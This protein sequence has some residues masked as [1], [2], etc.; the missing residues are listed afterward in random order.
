MSTLYNISLSDTEYISFGE[1]LFSNEKSYA[2][3]TAIYAGE[4]GVVYKNS[5]YNWGMIPRVMPKK[6]KKKFEFL[7]KRFRSTVTVSDYFL[8]SQFKESKTI[9]V[10]N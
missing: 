1:D 9:Q 2:M 7:R 4:S 10:K 8:E 5:E 6:L 3:N